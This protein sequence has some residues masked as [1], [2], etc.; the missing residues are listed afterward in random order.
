M[1]TGHSASLFFGA[2]SAEVLYFLRMQKLKNFMAALATHPFFVFGVTLALASKF[3][4]LQYAF[5]ISMITVFLICLYKKE[6]FFGLIE[7]GNFSKAKGIRTIFYNLFFLLITLG[8][9]G[10]VL[11]PIGWISLLE[12]LLPGILLGIYFYRYLNS[13]VRK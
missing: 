4:F 12:G 6:T 3:S 5:I 11:F 9:F 1:P 2:Q 8:L 10:S 7:Y 13:H